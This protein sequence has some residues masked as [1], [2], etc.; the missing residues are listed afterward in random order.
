MWT[1]ARWAP[2][3]GESDVFLTGVATAVSVAAAV[4]DRAR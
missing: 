3:L 1:A 4:A 2:L